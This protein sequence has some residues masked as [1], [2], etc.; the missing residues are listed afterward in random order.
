VRTHLIAA[1]LTCLFACASAVTAAPADPFDRSNVP[2]EQQP[3]DPAAAKIVLVAG[4]PD[5]TT[6]PGD[7]E[8]FAGC[9]MLYRM[10][11]QTPG[12]A[13][14]VV[15]G[16]WPKNPKATFEDAKA[17]VFFMNG[18]GKQS[19]VAHAAEVDKLAA[20]GVGIVHL[21]QCVD[22]PAE[23]VPTA[24]RWLGGAYHPKTGA[25]GHWDATYDAFPEHPITRGVTPFEAG[26]RGVH[27]Q[28]HVRRRHEGR[29]AAA[30]GAEPQGEAGVLRR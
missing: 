11:R 24:V 26:E 30:A 28:A 22:Y 4:G 9:A 21:H 3:A 15:E 7:H 17:V 27:L 29:H 12:V 23:M 10:L 20:A 19:T 6:N 8:H 25:R 13:P 5:A 14:V 2:V 1:G 16:G 18:G